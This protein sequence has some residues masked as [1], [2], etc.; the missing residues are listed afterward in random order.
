MLVLT[1]RPNESVFVDGPCKITVLKSTCRLGFEGDAR[2]VRSELV[3]KSGSKGDSKPL[4]RLVDDD[5]DLLRAYGRYLNH[6]G[7][8]VQTF[9]NGGDFLKVSENFREASA[10]VLD[11]RLA[12]EDLDGLQILQQLQAWDHDYP[13]ILLTGYGDVDT[14]R[15]A[16]LNGC[17]TF[18]QKPLMPQELALTIKEATSKRGFANGKGLGGVTQMG[19]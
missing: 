2:V 3:E 14:C 6:Y 16:F 12:D 8:Q 13:V 7:F 1:R 15:R 19:V 10:V 5:P 4:V 9:I 18:L 17:Y 11:L